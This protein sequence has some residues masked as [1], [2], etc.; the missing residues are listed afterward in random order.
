MNKKNAFSLIE[1]SIVILIIGI[2]VAGVTQSSRLIN[3]M[4][5]MSARS[6]TLASPVPTVKNLIAW[7][8]S[9]GE[10]SFNESE[11][12]NGT[13]L[14]IWYDSNIQ[15]SVKLNGIQNTENNKPQYGI[16]E[17]SALPI[18]KFTNQDFFDLPDGTVPFNN[19]PYTVFLVSRVE[20]LCNCG[21]LGSGVSNT[22]QANSFRY[23]GSAGIFNNY[24]FS[25][26]LTLINVT[27]AKQM[28]IFAFTYNQ[29][30]REGFVNGVSRG[31]V[32]SSNRAST[33][34]FNAIGATQRGVPLPEYMIGQI[35]EIIIF[36][37]ALNAEERRSIEVYLGKKWSI[38]IS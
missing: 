1:L 38:K 29:A 17:Q 30:T 12:S 5:L 10:K 36:D 34:N 14:S 16:D 8:E 3:Q 32:A 13:N 2:L 7:Y 25:V 26:D 15:S 4:R 6:M 21:V 20:T 31:T 24:W 9:V 33:S 22:N 19:M 11:M 23:D 35:G 18:V 28:Q 27:I 37:R